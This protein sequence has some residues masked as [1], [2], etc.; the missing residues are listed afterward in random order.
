MVNAL[1][2]LVGPAPLAVPFLNTRLRASFFFFFFFFFES[3]RERRD[4]AGQGPQHEGPSTTGVFR[5]VL[6]HH[7]SV[8]AP[9]PSTTRLLHEL[10]Q[11]AIQK[12][13]ALIGMHRVEAAKM[14]RQRLNTSASRG[15][16]ML[17]LDKAA[18]IP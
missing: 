12:A 11:L 1:Q 4:G 5:R 17:P 6:K 10:S 13:V 8:S 14:G 18:S 2:S 16:C 9:S 7:W 15:G 3:R